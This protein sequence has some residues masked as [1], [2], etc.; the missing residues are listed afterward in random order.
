MKCGLT[1][2]ALKRERGGR[3]GERVRLYLRYVVLGTRALRGTRVLCLDDRR[4]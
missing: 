3:A 1:R 4:G 2:R